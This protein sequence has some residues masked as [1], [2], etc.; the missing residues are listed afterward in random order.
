M[1]FIEI[2][3]VFEQYPIILKD[4]P[5]IFHSCRERADYALLFA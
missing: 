1:I 5:I 4:Y 2:A 3:T